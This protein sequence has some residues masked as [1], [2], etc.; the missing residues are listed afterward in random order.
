MPY[1]YYVQCW[2]RPSSGHDVVRKNRIMSLLKEIASLKSFQEMARDV[3]PVDVEV[4]DKKFQSAIQRFEE[5]HEG[6]VVEPLVLESDNEITDAEKE[7]LPEIQKKYPEAKIFS[8]EKMP[9]LTPHK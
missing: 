3:F 2:V 5:Q 8:W 1:R 4:T 6:L 7:L 9:N